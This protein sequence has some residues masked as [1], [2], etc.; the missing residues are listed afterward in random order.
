MDGGETGASDIG[1]E[2][3][4]PKPPVDPLDSRRKKLLSQSRRASRA[5]EAR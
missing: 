1:G 5:V 2:P 3:R 4:P